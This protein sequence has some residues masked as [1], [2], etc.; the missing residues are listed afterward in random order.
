[1]EIIVMLVAGLFLSACSRYLNT[2]L[3]V[4]LLTLL[5][6]IAGCGGDDAPESPTT[7]EK[8][9]ALNFG[10]D[11]DTYR[12]R[13]LFKISNLPVKSWTVKEVTNKVRGDI[14]DDDGRSSNSS[15][16]LLLM[17]PVAAADFADTLRE[18]VENGIPYIYIVIEVQRISNEVSSRT[19]A[20]DLIVHQEGL[21]PNSQGS[22]MSKDRRRGYYIE[23][24]GDP[25]GFKWKQ[26]FFVRSS[27]S[28]KHVY[29]LL[30]AAPTDQYNTYLPVYDRIIA[31]VEF[32]L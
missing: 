27:E 16:S 25:E 17:Q 15:I 6:G 26:T 32:R 3:L 10:L 13:R 21:K 19:F 9:P 24:E 20:L 22:V 29:R 12:N 31:S 28:N 8:Q 5:I 14:D 18:A 11:G 7:A 23:V 2:I 30:Y 1:M 4:A